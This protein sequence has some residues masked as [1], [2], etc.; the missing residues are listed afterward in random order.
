[1]QNDNISCG[2]DFHGQSTPLN[3]SISSNDR[4]YSWTKSYCSTEEETDFT[5]ELHD[6]TLSNIFKLES[7]KSTDIDEIEQKIRQISLKDKRVAKS[8]RASRNV[9]D[10]EHTMKFVEAYGEI[11]FSKKSKRQ[12]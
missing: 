10:L 1:M 6:N 4:S 12:S 7:I 8:P 5:I 3:E 2:N 11:L 9:S